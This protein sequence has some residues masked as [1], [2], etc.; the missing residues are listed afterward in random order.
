MLKPIFFLISFSVLIASQTASAQISCKTDWAGNYVCNDY[1]TGYSTSTKKDWA[2]NDVT[3][4]NRGNSMSC[5]T[6]WAGNYVC[7]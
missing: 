6:D 1:S 5:K 3:T 2:G 7:N 4:D